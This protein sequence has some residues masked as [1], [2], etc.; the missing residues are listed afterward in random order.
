M[1]GIVAPFILDMNFF[2]SWKLRYS[3]R[4]IPSKKNLPAMNSLAFAFGLSLTTVVAAAHRVAQLWKGTSLFVSLVCRH[5]DDVTF[6][7]H[8]CFV[9]NTN[10]QN[11]DDERRRTWRK[12]KDKE[13]LWICEIWTKRKFI[14]KSMQLNGVGIVYG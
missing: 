6:K 1:P 13:I 11:H 10:S 12:V 8:M 2:S 7:C 3:H 14:V 5:P 9:D 4:N